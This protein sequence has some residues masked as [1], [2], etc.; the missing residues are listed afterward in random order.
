L[1]SLLLRGL[2]LKL[3]N[4]PRHRQ[5]SF[6][7]SWPYYA[8]GTVLYSACLYGI[9]FI[10]VANMAGNCVSFASRVLLASH[11]GEGA[12][13]DSAQ[14]RA[15]AT[16]AAFFSCLIHALSRRG[17]ILLNNFLATVK[18]CILLIIPFVTFAVL[19]KAIKDQ[20]GVPVPNVFEQNMDSR[21]AF[22]PPK[23]FSLPAG[24]LVEEALESGTANGYASA[25][26]SIGEHLA[27]RADFGA[28]SEANAQEFLPLLDLTSQTMYVRSTARSSET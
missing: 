10:C 7:Y 25:F 28:E 21:V 11:P 23:N 5:L 2:L 17:G 18:V 15:I 16:A 13:L 20:N 27:A 6:V 12:D 9:S 24:A 14:V 19:G 4:T 3:V 8:K 1:A 26:L 22:Q